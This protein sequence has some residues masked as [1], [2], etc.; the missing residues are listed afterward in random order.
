MLQRANKSL[1]LIESYFQQLF[2]IAS[3]LYRDMLEILTVSENF[4]F[5]AALLRMKSYSLAHT[6][7]HMLVFGEL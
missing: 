6:S 3:Q 7:E 5:C 1:P 2:I 4:D